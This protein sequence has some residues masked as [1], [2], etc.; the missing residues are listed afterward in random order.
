[1]PS[2]PSA[3]VVFR[4]YEDGI[5]G[6]GQRIGKEL[7]EPLGTAEG[8]SKSEAIRA[9]AVE[10]GDNGAPLEG[11]YDAVPARSWGRGRERPRRETVVTWE[12]IGEPDAEATEAAE[13][14]SA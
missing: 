4:L 7:W 5:S 11:L 3:Y 8:S 9:K 1:M 6:T 14:Q 12:R 2:R 10:L 13:P